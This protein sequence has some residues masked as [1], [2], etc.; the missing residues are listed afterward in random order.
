[1]SRGASW[2][3]QVRAPRWALVGVVAIAALGGGTGRAQAEQCSNPC[4][5]GSGDLCL[6]IKQVVELGRAITLRPGRQSGTCGGVVPLAADQVALTWS[7]DAAGPFTTVPVTREGAALTW[8]PERAGP[9]FLE[10]VA[11]DGVGAPDR[12]VVIVVEPSTQ[13]VRLQLRPG[14]GLAAA[15]TA[16]KVRWVP[17]A[18][19]D[20]FPRQRWPVWRDNDGAGLAGNPLRLPPGRYDVEWTERSRGRAQRGVTTIDVAGPGDVAVELTAAAPTPPGSSS[21]A[22]PTPPGSSG[23]SRCL[24]AK[25]APPPSSPR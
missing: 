24:P 19:S 25:P 12:V 15:R 18:P 20:R 2:S 9:Y 13:A 6:P 3:G 14:K 10:A 16:I 4:E 21:A 22:V 23:S 11:R 5:V 7:R 17:S 1:M 8:T